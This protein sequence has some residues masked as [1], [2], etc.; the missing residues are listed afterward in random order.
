M[1]FDYDHLGRKLKRKR[2]QL[3]EDPRV[4]FIFTSPSGDGLK[5]GYKL[6]NPITDFETFSAIYKYYANQLGLELG[7]KAD[8]TSAASNPCYF[9]ID[10]EIYTQAKFADTY[11]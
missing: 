2:K 1:I 9:S 7:E 11:N 3:I 10:A 8:K 6:D 5:V 4:N